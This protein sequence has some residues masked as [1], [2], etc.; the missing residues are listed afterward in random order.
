MVG[1]LASLLPFLCFSHFRLLWMALYGNK[2]EIDNLIEC[3]KALSWGIK[4]PPSWREVSEA[5]IAAGLVLVGRVVFEREI[6]LHAVNGGL[7]R[8]W[9][10]DPKLDVTELTANVFLCE[11]SHS[12]AREKVLDSQPWNIKGYLLVLQP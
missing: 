4:P 8:A 1:I 11:F 7:R 5:E 10:F 2:T 6:P 12:E 9:P 3:T